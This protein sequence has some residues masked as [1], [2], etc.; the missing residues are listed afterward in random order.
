MGVKNQRCHIDHTYDCKLYSDLDLS[1]L[2][3][4]YTANHHAS[5]GTQWTCENELCKPYKHGHGVG[6]D[7]KTTATMENVAN[8]DICKQKCLEGV[9]G[10]HGLD[11][12][13]SHSCV[14]FYYAK[15]QKR[16]HFVETKASGVLPISD[17]FNDLPWGPAECHIL[18]KKTTECIQ[19]D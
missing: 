16:C 4:G 8:R 7:H 2:S 3:I 19:W 6:G 14:Y 11:T 13:E 5:W 12:P 1:Q 17:K 9:T 10:P 15:R 18:C